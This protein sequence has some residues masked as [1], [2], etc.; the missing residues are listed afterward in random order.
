MGD[1]L[2]LGGV[3]DSSGSSRSSYAG[4]SSALICFSTSRMT[5]MM[6]V[7]VVSQ[8]DNAQSLSYRLRMQGRREIGAVNMFKFVGPNSLEIG[9]LNLQAS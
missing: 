4:G 2:A 3:D 9:N 7:Q 1:D 5:T 8:A 6:V